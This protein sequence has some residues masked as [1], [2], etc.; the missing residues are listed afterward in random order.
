M[1]NRIAA[2]AATTVMLAGGALA[3]ASAA[4]AS[5]APP[6]GGGWDHTWTTVDAKHGGTVYVEE[7]GDV[8]SLCDTAADGYAPRAEVS[9]QDSVG[10]Y[11]IKYTI[12]GAGGYGACTTY[13]ASNGGKYD[14]PE[15]DNIMI[16]IWLGPTKPGPGFKWYTY[17]NDH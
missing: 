4:S 11:D 15:N 14:L 13:S 1:R 3:T 2:L 16:S 10:T 8:V 6:G 17:L 9:T 12:T 5:V 7:H